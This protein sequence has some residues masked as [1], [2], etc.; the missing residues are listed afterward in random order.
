MPDDSLLSVEVTKIISIG[1][2]RKSSF[3]TQLKSN[4]ANQPIE[5]PENEEASSLG[6]AII[7]AVDEGYFAS[8]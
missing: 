8:F 2:G 1:G 7:A 3:W 4:F 6:A 5:I